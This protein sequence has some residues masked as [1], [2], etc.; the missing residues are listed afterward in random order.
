[1]AYNYVPI[2]KSKPAEIWAWQNA[3]TN[4]LAA[5][6]VLFELVPTD[7][8][9]SPV[10][11]FVNRLTSNYPSGQVITAD[12]DLFGQGSSVVTDLSQELYQRNVYERP[13]FRLSDTTAILNQIQQ[14]CVLHGQGA[15]LRLGTDAQDPDPNV[16]VQHVTN[17]M[18]HLGLNISQIDLIIDFKVVDSSRNVTRCVP[19]ALNMLRWATTCGA[20]RS[21]TLASGAFPES[22]SSFAL[23]QATQLNRFDA[24]FFAHVTQGNPAI[25]P[26]FGDYGINYPIFGVP[27][28]R[29]PNPNLRY[30]DGLQWQVERERKSLPGNQSFFTLCRR[31]VQANYWAGRGYSA[32]DA[33]IERCSRSTGSPGSATSWLSFGGSHHIAHVVDRLAT[34]GVP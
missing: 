1:M 29:A 10:I 26:D 7:T 8:K 3:S 24:M 15:C 4:V 33:E 9:T 32:G 17:I 23:G 14:A 21:V 28:P 31:V 11:N 27:P 12:C 6:R 5:S 13:V 20:W 18:S 16:P 2:L 30:T 34:L 25:T 19:L 22:I